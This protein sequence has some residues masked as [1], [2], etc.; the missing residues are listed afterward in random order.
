MKRR[1]SPIATANRLSH[2]Q[3]KRQRPPSGGYARGDET[4]L[5]ILG[6]ALD[7]F[8]AHGFGGASTR[9]IANKANVNLP[10]LQ[11]YFNGKEG[12]YLACAE[13]I[14][15][16]LDARLGPI[17]DRIT[18]TLARE[19]PSRARL[20]RM[21]QEFLDGFTDLFLGESELEKWVMFIIREQAHPTKAF[22]IIFERVMRRVA[23]ACTALV[24][25]LLDQPE[26][27]PEVRIR[28]LALIGQIIFFR[29]AREAALRLMRWTDFEEAH[30]QLVKRALYE[31][32]ARGLGGQRTIKRARTT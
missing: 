29:I 2:G 10:A 25:R 5:R 23:A 8:G 21:L 22:D 30:L 16:R 14:A 15:Q 28:A 13:H 17:A 27:N 32:T 9:M 4:R 6:A 20:F 18:K 11:Y 24:G 19:A 31:Q 7:V 12:V 3:S 1:V 26:S